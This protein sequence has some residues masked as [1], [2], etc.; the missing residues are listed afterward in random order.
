[1]S[2]NILVICEKQQE[3]NDLE[4]VVF[5][6]RKGCD[7]QKIYFVDFG[8][9]TGEILNYNNN[10]FDHVFVPTG[11]FNSPYYKLD[12]LKKIVT[13]LYGIKSLTSLA[14]GYNITHI[15]YGVPIVFFRALNFNPLRN[16]KTFSYVRSTVTDDNVKRKNL[17]VFLRK[18][19]NFI[20]WTKPYVADQFF[21]IDDSTKKYI[22]N[23]Y[24][25]C[26]ASKVRNIGSIYSYS[27]LKE[28][29]LNKIKKEASNLDVRNLCLISSAFYWHGDLEAS[30]QQVLVFEDISRRVNEYNLQEVKN[31]LNLYIKLHPRDSVEYYSGLINQGGVEVIE[32]LNMAELDDSYCFV[33]ILSTLS[34]ELK[35]AGFQSVYVSNEFFRIKYNQWYEKNNIVPLDISEKNLI[36]SFIDVRD[37]NKTFL[38]NSQ[39]PQE[40]LAG[41]LCKSFSE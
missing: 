24:P 36:D 14:K 37:K 17:P 3:L 22:K 30:N 1:M 33:S 6:L 16:Y 26:R 27:L 38:V 2:K 8:K 13:I 40:L 20:L 32:G 9:F 10:L 11:L 4:K 35:I 29:E 7:F 34:F 28:R 21:C 5:E 31:P 39:Q 19:L 25:N 41:F 23:M 15:L 18:L 12:I